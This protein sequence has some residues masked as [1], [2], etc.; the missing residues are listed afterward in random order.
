M[1]H[2]DSPSSSPEPPPPEPDVSEEGDR[3]NF[4][5]RM[6]S[7]AMVGGLAGGYGVFAAIAGRFLVPRGPEDRGWMFVSDVKRLKV[8]DSLVF[9]TP[10]GAPVNV[11]R[12]GEAG[13]VSDFVALSSTC[14]HLGCQVHWESQNDRF[15]CPCHNGVFDRSGK[16][17][18][19]PPGEAGQ[20]LL[21]YPL[22][23]EKGLLYIEVPLTSLAEGEEPRPEGDGPEY[24]TGATKP[25]QDPCLF[26]PPGSKELG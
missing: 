25:G 23:I 26:R 17:I 1:A 9:R 2:P 6:S 5:S 20:S 18:G 8:G 15:F 12:Q 14:P 7:V 11:A 13:D 19:G 3:R 16:G 4:L 24:A 22:R 21:R 10:A